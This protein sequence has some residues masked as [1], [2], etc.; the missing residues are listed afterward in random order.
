M[1]EPTLQFVGKEQFAAPNDAAT[2][3]VI[4]VHGLGGH[5]I[6]TWSATND[7]S[8]FWPRW[9][10][11]DT[12]S[13]NV[14]TAGYDSSLFAG[15]F[16]GEGSSLSDRATALLDLMASHG[17]GKRPIV[18]V[19]HSLGGLIVK[20]MLRIC[21]DN[22]TEKCKSILQQTR[23]TVFCGTPHA[24]S[25][26]AT[27]IKNILSVA[28]SKHI[29]ELALSD[30]ALQDLNTWFR[31][32][33]STNGVT[34]LAYHE[35]KKTNGLKV[36]AKA[37]ADP[38]LAGCVCTAIDADHFGVCK[39]ETHQSQLYL[40]V[41]TL[42]FGITEM[43]KAAA[44]VYGNGSALAYASG[45]P[46]T[47]PVPAPS[48]AL[49]PQGVV[50]MALDVT[51]PAEP[52][53]STKPEILFDFEYFTTEAPHDRRP[54]AAKLE[55]GG[56]SFETKEAERRKE[57]FAMA[58]RR[59]AIQSSSLARY[60]RLMADVETRFKRHVMPAIAKG[61]DETK[62]NKLVQTEVINAV[63]VNQLTETTDIDSA[64]VENALYYLTGNCHVRWDAE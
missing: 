33:I 53:I 37:S 6:G 41:K 30:E 63:V 9:L 5:P 36:V 17:L 60:T 54:L 3:D 49:V 25:E 10:A 57:R 56:R 42:V 58:L 23:A 13:A 7:Q 16:S 55:A 11:I 44:V 8:G 47:L 2:V 22:G 46:N 15:A 12:P 64:I 24:G 29:K 28:L 48:T 35:T 20:Q 1:V 38:C 4:F 61:D 14:W 32:W 21:S 31:N 51:L 59:H 27:A 43:P 45:N 52:T 40:A 19:T 62:I 26:L 34:V 18:F 39:P 50:L